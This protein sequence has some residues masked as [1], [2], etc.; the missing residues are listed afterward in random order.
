MLISSFSLFLL[1]L[2]LENIV[3]APKEL[4]EKSQRQMDLS[5]DHLSGY[6]RRSG[7]SVRKETG[8]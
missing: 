6:Q 1:K 2:I 3:K 4:A 8:M 5:S 7:E